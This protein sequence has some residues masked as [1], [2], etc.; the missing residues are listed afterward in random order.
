MLTD[1]T[2]ITDRSLLRLVSS[3]PQV[4]L[5]SR[6]ATILFLTDQ[7][8]VGGTLA[9]TPAVFAVFICNLGSRALDN[10]RSARL[11]GGGD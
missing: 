5:L 7:F 8:L 6:V 9:Q 2:S 4:V 11:D 3:W 1:T 10:P